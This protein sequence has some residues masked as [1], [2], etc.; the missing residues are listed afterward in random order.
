MSLENGIKDAITKKLE[1][2][3]VE[4]LIEEQ[5]EKGIV[6]ALNNILGNYGDVTKIIEDKVKSVM[7]PYLESYDYSKYIVKLDSILVDVLKSSALE[8]KNLLTN[9]KELMIEDERKESIKTSELF[10]EWGKYVEKN[11]DT[12][13]LEVE[14]DGEPCYEQVDVTLTVDEDES[15]N[16]SS[17]EY[18]TLVFECEKD[19]SMNFAIRLSKYNKD[20]D[21]KWDIAYD[22]A[23]DIKSL[24]YL[25]AFEIFLMKLVQNHTTL[26]MDITNESDEVTPEA[27]FN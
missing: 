8:N 3:T 10:E 24:R 14:Y 21:G 9:F 20:K 26:E 18:A 12:T 5:L 27:S 17:F 7:I 4:R 11:V 15:R 2:G 16:W 25:N 22:T 6:K 19:E 1:D 13:D 23:H